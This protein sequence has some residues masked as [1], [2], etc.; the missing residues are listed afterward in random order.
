MYELTL[1]TL[2]LRCTLDSIRTDPD[3]YYTVQ[4][5]LLQLAN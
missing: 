4:G 5:L 2:F 3:I 1:N